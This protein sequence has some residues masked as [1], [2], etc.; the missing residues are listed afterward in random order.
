MK[1]HSCK[2]GTRRCSIQKHFDIVDIENLAFNNMFIDHMEGRSKSVVESEPRAPPATANV[3]V[4]RYP[5]QCLPPELKA[6]FELEMKN[7]NT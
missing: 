6:R 5:R 3:K 1:V 2:N 7:S 4:S